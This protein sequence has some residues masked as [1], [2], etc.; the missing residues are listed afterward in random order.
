MMSNHRSHVRPL[1]LL[2]TTAALTAGFAWIL[3]LWRK[4]SA[5]AEE[6]EIAALFRQLQDLSKAVCMVVSDARSTSFSQRNLA[7]YLTQRGFEPSGQLLQDAKV[8]VSVLRDD[9]VQKA[10]SGAERG[11][12]FAHELKKSAVDPKRLA[13]LFPD[14]KASY[15]QQ[16]LDYGRNSRYGDQWRIS[17]Y[18]V[19]ME[20]WKPKILPHEPM[21]RCLGSVMSECVNMFEDWYCQLKGYRLGSKKF[22]VMN[23][24]VTRYRAV[25]GEEE[26]QKH[27]DGANVDG[28]VIL[29]LPT[30][31]PFEGGAL[32]VWD[33]KPKQE[34]VYTM[35]AGDCPITAR[36]KTHPVADVERLGAS[37]VHD[38]RTKQSQALPCKLRVFHLHIEAPA[39]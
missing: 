33:G 30:D 15:V 4:R 29:A 36:L 14:I 18:L 10:N 24:F 34:L 1:P 19:V 26:L 25:H 5:A 23:A 11:R 6:R 21:L 35:D 13:N 17:C 12:T 9:A 3:L 2:V 27:I 16:P 31:E 22:G 7:K 32:H 20:N 28:S 37:L 38:C 8:L 39:G